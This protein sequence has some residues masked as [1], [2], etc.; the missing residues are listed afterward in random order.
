[1]PA[2]DPIGIEIVEE[3][4]AIGFD[5]IELSLRDMAAAPDAVFEGMV[6]RIRTAGIRCEACNNFFPPE[7]RLTG[8]EARQTAALC[9]A[10]QAL[11]R[12][13]RLGAQSVVFGS[14]GSR[15][16]P[17]GF[18]Q[19]TAWKQLVVLL[20]NLGQ[21][22]ARHGIT[23]VIEHLNRQESNI[24]NSAAEGL[25][26]QQEVNHPNVQLLIDSYHLL[27]ESENPEIVLRA[28]MGVRHVHC[29]SGAGRKF[30]S[31][32]DAQLAALMGCLRGINYAGRCSIEAYTS[33][34]ARDAR[35]SLSLLKKI[36]EG[37]N[38]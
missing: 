18:S 15:N 20:Q 17:P 31:G 25:R 2:R 24:V 36:W 13:G 4:A 27:M 34:F 3:M 19:E 30:P 16:V 29:A 28:G 21:M 14:A 22:A 12:A 1:M 10:E 35:H 23:I 11:E 6:R 32:A 33:D 5:Y 38:E 7:I 37:K 8:V 26:L 9:Y